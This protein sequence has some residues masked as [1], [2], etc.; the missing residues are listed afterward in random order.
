MPENANCDI[1][2]IPCLKLDQYQETFVLSVRKTDGHEYEP[3]SLRSIIN[4]IARKLRDNKE[5]KIRP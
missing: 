3:S 2:E 4:N 5:T 1:H